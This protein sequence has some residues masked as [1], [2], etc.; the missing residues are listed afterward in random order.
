MKDFNGREQE[1]E[2]GK[3]VICE[4][5]FDGMTWSL[6]KYKVYEIQ[7]LMDAENRITLID[8]R[9]AKLDVDAERFLYHPYTVTIP[10]DASMIKTIDE[11]LHEI[12]YSWD[13]AYYPQTLLR[14]GDGLFHVNKLTI[15]P[16]W[17]EYKGE[18]QWLAS[19]LYEA[20]CRIYEV[21]EKTRKTHGQPKKYDGSEVE[22]S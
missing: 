13:Y 21:I 22:E 9:G 7:G 10:E 5:P 14:E 11:L 8:D 15:G 17:T 6:T 3:S 2:T 4:H 12:A 16:H 18:Y 20:L 19:G 1:W